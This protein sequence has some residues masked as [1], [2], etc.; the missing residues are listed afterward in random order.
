MVDSPS[1]LGAQAKKGSAV[2]RLKRYA[3]WVKYTRVYLL[4]VNVKK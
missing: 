1:P 4:Y 3:S 2:R